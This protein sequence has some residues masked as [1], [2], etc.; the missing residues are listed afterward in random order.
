MFLPPGPSM[1]HI[2]ELPMLKETSVHDL[3]TYA[4]IATAAALIVAKWWRC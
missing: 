4:A 3:P 1:A 2:P